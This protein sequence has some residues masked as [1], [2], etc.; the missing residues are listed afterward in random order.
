MI[1]PAAALLW[2]GHIAGNGGTGSRLGTAAMMASVYAL[3]L[4]TL[5]G[6]LTL[7]VSTTIG[8]GSVAARNTIVLGPSPSQT[9]FC[10]LVFAFVF[11]SIGAL[12][13]RPNARQ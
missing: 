12:L 4:T 8:T 5:T 7:D 11:G 3:L 9:F 1:I 13:R 10:G 2:G 6:L